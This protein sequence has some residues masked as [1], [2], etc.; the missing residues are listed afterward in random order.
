MAEWIGHLIS[1]WPTWAVGA[2]GIIIFLAG[3]ILFVGTNAFFTPTDE[4]TWPFRK[5]K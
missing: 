4:P 3:V 1:S 2:V 5:K